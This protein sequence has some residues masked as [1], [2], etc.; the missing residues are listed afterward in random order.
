VRAA[1]RVG[2][3]ANEVAHGVG[4]RCARPGGA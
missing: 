4:F 2:L 3:G 1:H